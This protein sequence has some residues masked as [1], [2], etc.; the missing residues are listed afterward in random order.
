MKKHLLILML[1]NLSVLTAASI[2]EQSNYP[3]FCLQAAK[4]DAV[5]S[6]FKRSP[7]YRPILEH[8]PFEQGLGYLSIIEAKYA[9][10][11]SHIDGFRKN[12]LLGNPETFNF[13]PV[14]GRMSPTTLRYM[15]VSGDLYSLFGDLTGKKIIE[16]GA[17]YGGQCK[18]ISELSDFS[19][20]TIVDLPEVILLAEKYLKALEIKDVNFESHDQYTK[21]NSYDLVISNY[22]FSEVSVNEQISYIENILNKSSCGY[23]TCNFVSDQFGIKSLSL[24]QLLAYLEQ[25]GRKIRVL[26][27]D[28]VTSSNNLIVVWSSNV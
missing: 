6:Q 2:S 26:P 12:D 11:L 13:G 19:S 15:K 5:F 1:L 27:E 22:A 8:V 14:V 17:G 24:G 7:S 4:D 16:I 9:Y 3:R 23:L 25:P 20:Y 21:S 18:I 10:L 28:P